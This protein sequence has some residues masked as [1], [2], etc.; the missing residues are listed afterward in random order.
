MTGCHNGRVE[1]D[2]KLEEC[3]ALSAL[4]DLCSLHRSDPMIAIQGHEQMENQKFCDCKAFR[5]EFS[6]GTDS[7]CAETS[8]AV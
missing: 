1:G 8:L 3:S 4:L 2:G 7:I 5:L 6:W